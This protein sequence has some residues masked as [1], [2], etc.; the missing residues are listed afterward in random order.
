MEKSPRS[1]EER[2]LLPAAEAADRLGVKLDSLYAYVSRGLLSRHRRAGE[3]GSWFDPGEIDRLV[4]RGRGAEGRARG[5]RS[6]SAVTAIED[7]RYFYRGLDPVALARERSF[8]QVAE[9][10]WT[11]VLPER[12]VA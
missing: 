9:L 4:G 12:P 3:R 11:G 7:G 10:L 6:E 2:S 8:E 5:V 1:L